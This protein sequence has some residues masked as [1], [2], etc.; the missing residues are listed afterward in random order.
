MR[1]AG[2]IQTEQFSVYTWCQSRI[3]QK[4][5]YKL[6]AE[7]QIRLPLNRYTS[8]LLK[9]RSGRVHGL[10]QTTHSMSNLQRDVPTPRS[11]QQQCLHQQRIPD[12]RTTKLRE[13][14]A[15]P[16]RPRQTLKFRA[17]QSLAR[18]IAHSS[19]VTTQYSGGGAPP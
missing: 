16:S 7:D 18:S 5:T 13:V 8:W 1:S 19:A 14:A 2:H 11:P 12:P 17:W 9:H 4:A 15:L 3:E 6:R 10:F